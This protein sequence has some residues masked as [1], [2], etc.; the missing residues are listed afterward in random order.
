MIR[1]VA[2]TRPDSNFQD[3]ISRQW[4]KERLSS[5]FSRSLSNTEVSSSSGPYLGAVRTLPLQSDS[6]STTDLSIDVGRR[7]GA[8]LRQLRRTHN[9]TQLDLAVTL[10]IDR[11]YLSSIECGKKGVSLATLEVIALGFRMK[12]SELLNDL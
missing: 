3:Q 12:L 7:F 9:L 8:R 5:V 4:M 6:G 10:G 1:K 11:C 2:M